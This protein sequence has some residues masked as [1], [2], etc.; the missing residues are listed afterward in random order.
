MLPINVDGSRYTSQVMRI[1][2]AAL[3][4]M[5]LRESYKAFGLIEKCC[6]KLQCGTNTSYD[7]IRGV[8]H[9]PI[10]DFRYKRLRYP[11]HA[12][13]LS[14]RRSAKIARE[15]EHVRIKAGLGHLPRRRRG[16]K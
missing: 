3:A 9:Q 11:A 7:L 16:R 8:D 15:P 13:K 10:F 6:G 14:L 1:Q 12:R 5:K 4:F 2:A